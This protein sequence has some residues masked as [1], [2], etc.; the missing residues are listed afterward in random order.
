[1]LRVCICTDSRMDLDLWAATL[2]GFP[3]DEVYFVGEVP[4]EAA[5]LKPFKSA[6]VV[7]DAK[8]IPGDLVVFSPL[9]SEK[10]PGRTPLGGMTHPEDATYFFGSDNGRVTSETI[11]LEPTQVVGIECKGFDHLFAHVAAAVVLH[12]RLVKRG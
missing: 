8:G 11:G 4:D 6:K 5:K 1:M 7:A 12:D 2:A 3:V 10:F 9:R